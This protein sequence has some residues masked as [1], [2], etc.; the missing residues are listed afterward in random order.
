MGTRQVTYEEYQ[1]MVP[2]DVE[3][4]P[5]F[6]YANK[7]FKN[8]WMEIGDF[9]Y[10]MP[11]I[12]L[13]DHKSK[14]RIGKFC[15]IAAGVKC[16]LGGNHNVKAVST[17]PFPNLKAAW[18]AAANVTTINRQD[19][20]SKGN[21]TIGNDV[22]IAHGAIIFSG[23]TIGDGAVIGSHSIVTKDVPPYAVAAGNPARVR[24]MRFTELQ[25]AALLEIHWWDWPE[26]KIQAYA[27]LIAGDDIDHF[28]KVAKYEANT[29]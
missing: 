25:I 22:W 9:T 10:G 4:V 6:L 18:P 5:G 28:I 27:D 1:K 17:Y 2:P 15:S 21:I 14:V 16:Y 3:G 8:P 13:P 19:A 23:V 20:Y 24:K 29:E 12:L 11:E 7:H 26:K